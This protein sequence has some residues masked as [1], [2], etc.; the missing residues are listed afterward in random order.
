MRYFAAL[1]NQLNKTNFQGS[2]GRWEIMLWF[3]QLKTLPNWCYVRKWFK[4]FWG[5]FIPHCLANLILENSFSPFHLNFLPEITIWKSLWHSKQI[6]F[7]SSYHLPY[8][9]YESCDYSPLP[10]WIFTSWATSWG[11][12][13]SFWWNFTT[14]SIIFIQQNLCFKDSKWDENVWW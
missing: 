4:E 1:Q 5:P 9:L 10:K 7:S 3:W 13:Q 2:F 6:S 8:D 12:S 14:T 11:W